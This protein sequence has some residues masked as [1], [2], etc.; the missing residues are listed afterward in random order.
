MPV[1]RDI[2]NHF[3]IYGVEYDCII[4]ISMVSKNQ[5]HE[6]MKKLMDSISFEIDDQEYQF[7]GE[8]PRENT[9]TLDRKIFVRKIKDLKESFW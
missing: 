6:L 8:H 5:D 1:S 2:S 9:T 4:Q 3:F 7:V